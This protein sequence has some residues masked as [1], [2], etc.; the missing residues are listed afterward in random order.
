M[1]TTDND[2]S[3]EIELPNLGSTNA[4]TVE[5][6]WDTPDCHCFN[7]A[8]PRRHHPAMT[9]ASVLFAT[10]ALPD[11]HGTVY[12]WRGPNVG[13]VLQELAETM[14]RKGNQDA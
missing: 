8:C 12:M 9:A 14:Q 4:L 6:I 7:P 1:F 11:E 10:K 2:Q 5:P 3:F 13:R